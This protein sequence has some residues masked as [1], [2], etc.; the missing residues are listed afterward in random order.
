MTE[1]DRLEE[2]LEKLFEENQQ[3][4]YESVFKAGIEFGIAMQASNNLAY[5]STYWKS[6]NAKNTLNEELIKLRFEINEKILKF[7]MLAIKLQIEKNS[8]W[9]VSTQNF[10][11]KFKDE[12]ASKC[13]IQLTRAIR[14][15]NEYDL[16]FELGA[17]LIDVLS[18][19]S[20]N[21]LYSCVYESD[22]DTDEL[23]VR[24]IEQMQSISYS[25]WHGVP[26]LSIDQL[27]EL[28]EAL[29]KHYLKVL[30][31]I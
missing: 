27:V 29:D 31:S 13:G 22:N 30:L 26:E 19:Y 24:D 1:L 9:Y 6:E 21:K 16:S 18:K 11:G 7:L 25:Q 17:N 5:E 23:A 3:P 15:A 14:D 4:S 20:S 10:G 28:S 2:A 12:I 8:Y